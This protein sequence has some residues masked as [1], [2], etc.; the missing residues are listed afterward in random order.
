[1][2]CWGCGQSSEGIRGGKSQCSQGCPMLEGVSFAQLCS[3]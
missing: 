1:M 2:G 3:P